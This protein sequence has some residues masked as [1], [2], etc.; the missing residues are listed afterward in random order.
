MP[1]TVPTISELP[2]GPLTGEKSGLGQNVQTTAE[3]LARLRGENPAQPPVSIVEE[4]VKIVVD[5][6]NKS[7]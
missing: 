1:E 5:N 7:N 2:A 6:S 3:H 4:A